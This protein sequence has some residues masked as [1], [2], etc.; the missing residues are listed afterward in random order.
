MKKSCRLYLVRHGQTE[1]NIEGRMQGQKDSSLTAVGISQAEAMGLRLKSVN[2][3]A[4]FSS[5]LLRAY[6]TA[7]IIAKERRLAVI[8][9]RELRERSFGKLDGKLV[10]QVRK[11]LEQF[12]H[13]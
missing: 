7:Q 10:S 3:A 9:R 11:E 8:A 5:D 6:R 12:Y 1:W 2:F 13:L 4:A